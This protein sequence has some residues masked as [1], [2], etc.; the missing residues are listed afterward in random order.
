MVIATSLLIAATFAAQSQAPGVNVSNP[1]VVHE[2]DG[3]YVIEFDFANKTGEAITAWTV[4]LKIHLSD[5][6]DEQTGQGK[7]GVLQYAGLLPPATAPERESAVPARSV[8]RMGVLYLPQK[9]GTTV[10]SIASIT[11]R[12][13]I[14]ADGSWFGD[15]R[16]VK[17]SFEM[18]GRAADACAALL[19]ILRGLQQAGVTTDALRATIAR[20]PGR[21]SSGFDPAQNQVLRRNIELLLAGRMKVTQEQAVQQWIDRLEAEGAAYDAHRREKESRRVAPSARMMSRP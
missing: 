8:V 5:G 6:T 14:F 20:I 4:D 12:K 3:F 1:A 21:D 11:L 2:P 10:L 17:S 7:D 16:E 9:T 18:R 19:P 13:A 15:E